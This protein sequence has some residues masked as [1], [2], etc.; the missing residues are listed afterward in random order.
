MASK[1]R[2]VTWG[3]RLALVVGLAAPA[4]VAADVIHLKTGGAIQVDAWRDVGDAIEFTRGG[5]IIRIAKA[6]I[7]RIDGQTTST[8]LRMYSAPASVG[9]PASL[10]EPAATKEML[11]L[12]RQG[13]A[14]FGQSVLTSVE[15]AGAFRRLGEKWQALAVPDA[16]TAVHALGQQALQVA[17]EAHTAESQGTV[18]DVKERLEAARSGIRDTVSEVRKVGGEG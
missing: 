12:L 15:K 5:G 6:E 10:D 2:A 3:W 16:L 13:E 11:D 4:V 14:L 9:R 7:A 8:D 18:P 1:R 17:M